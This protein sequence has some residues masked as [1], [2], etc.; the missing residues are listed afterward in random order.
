MGVPRRENAE[1]RPIR[2][3]ESDGEH[4]NYNNYDLSE[5]GDEINAISR[6]I[7]V[8]QLHPIRSKAAK[9][10]KMGGAK[11]DF[12]DIDT[13]G[14]NVK[15]NMGMRKWRRVEH[16]RIM[17]SF[18]DLDDICEDGSDIATPPTTAFDKLFQDKENMKIWNEFCSRDEVDQRRI[19]NGTVK[20]QKTEEI[21]TTSSGE[22]TSC[23]G[24]SPVKKPVKRISP[25]CGAACFDRIDAKSRMVLLGRKVNWAFIDF[26]ERELRN[27]FRIDSRNQQDTEA[28]F[29]GHYPASSDRLLAHIVAQWLGLSSQSTTDPSLKERITE[30]RNRRP[31][32]PPQT[33][34]IAHLEGRV[35]KRDIEF[36]PFE[37]REGQEQE[38]EEEDQGDIDPDTSFVLADE[39]E[40]LN[41]S[42][43]PPSA[44][45]EESPRSD[46]EESWEKIFLAVF[47]YI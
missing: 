29:I 16:A 37:M 44:S 25:Y 28:V 2:I 45:E 13:D 6:R 18:T 27:V 31:L 38:E 7:S 33:S 19:L 42:S 46:S 1:L 32:I 40:E 41:V 5:S 23:S 4:H 43:D 47:S 9:K 26:L 21:P 11:L 34:L 39:L 3:E 24:K 8:E 35:L 22:I 10:L 30:F 15:R 20:L 17:L 36:V 12:K 14:V